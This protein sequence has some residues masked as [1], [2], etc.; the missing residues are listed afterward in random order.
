MKNTVTASCLLIIVVLC[1]AGCASY[2]PYSPPR[3]LPDDQ[4]NIPEPRPRDTTIVQDAFEYGVVVP[5]NQLFDFARHIRSL[6]RNKRQALNLDAFGEVRDSSW[7][8]NRNARKP[9]SLEELAQGPDKGTGPETQGPWTITSAKVEG[10]TPGFNIK[11]ARGDRYLIKFDPFGYQELSS[12]AEVITGKI[13][14]AAGYNVPENY[15]VTFDPAILRMEENIQLQNEKG[16]RCE[17][18]DGD[19][20]RIMQKVEPLPDGRVRALASKYLE[21]VPLGGFRYLGRRQDDPNDIVDHEY[22]RELRGMYVMCAWLKHFDIK[23]ANSLDMYVREGTRQFI[24]HYLIDFGST[25]GGAPEGPMDAFRG[26]ETDFDMGAGFGNLLTLGLK[27]KDWEKAPQ[28][29][30]PS[31]GRFSAVDFKPGNT[32]MNILNPA[33]A[34]RTNLDGYWGAKLVM[35]FSDEQLKVLVREGQFSDPA[36]EEYLLEVL[37]LRRDMTGRYW[38]SRVNCLDHFT[39]D[40]SAAGLQEL[41]FTDLGIKGKIW[42]DRETRY[43]AGLRINGETVQEDINLPE[44]TVIQM[45]FM[46]DQAE[47]SGKR[48]KSERGHG[49]E[50]WELALYI[51]R[52]F[53]QTFGKWVK[54]YLSHDAVSGN[55]RL[56]GLRL[57]D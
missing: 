42:S 29:E 31:V 18:T 33:F 25:L 46:K 40:E 21:G 54:V 45:A 56:L 26:H 27:V 48:K 32:D 49:Q 36:A 14:H 41:R 1:L 39:L 37:K 7:F 20:S 47:R 3:L 2:T 11:D 53:G 17:M 35:S 16:V 43:R 22:R 28:V 50:E 10:Y 51:S 5:T 34:M 13:F 23:D 8:T 24:K 52:D 15:V 55:F 9:L 30:F 12:A 6:S 19:F 57:Q 44:G 38:Y 4:Q